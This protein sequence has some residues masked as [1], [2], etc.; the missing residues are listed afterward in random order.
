[1]T[2]LS[3]APQF[4]HG[5]RRQ[6]GRLLA[7][8][9]AR[10]LYGAPC[11]PSSSSENPCSTPRPAVRGVRRG[12][13]HPVDDLFETMDAANGVGLAANQIGVDRASSS[14]TA[15]TRR[16]ERP[17]RRRQP[18]AQ[19]PPAP[20]TMP[21][22]EDDDEGCL[23][24]PGESFPTG[25]AEH[26]GSAAST[27]TASVVVRGTGFL[28]RCLQHETDHLDGYIYLDRLVGRYRRAA[29]RPRPRLGG[30]RPRVDPTRVGRRPCR[31]QR[32]GRHEACNGVS[33]EAWTSS[34]PTPG[35][36]ARS[37]RRGPVGGG[38]ARGP[39]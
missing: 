4:N 38:G 33:T 10:E 30:P 11:V 36:S 39:G 9:R 18:G 27:S 29:R 21:D 23:S 28:A 7:R 15:R 16:G 26:A 37:R 13:A 6:R 19:P 32:T 20:E 8:D 3:F 12:A 34:M 2:R 5:R 22:P 24:V 25:R 1:M 31:A 35:R 17:R 14:S